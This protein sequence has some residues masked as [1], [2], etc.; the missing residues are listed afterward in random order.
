MSF[1]T[2]IVIYNKWLK[3]CLGGFNKEVDTFQRVEP[4]GSLSYISSIR[5]FIWECPGSV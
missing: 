1:E 2:L 3:D 4:G 5:L